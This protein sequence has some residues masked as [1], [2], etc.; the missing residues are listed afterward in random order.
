MANALHP[1]FESFQRKYFIYICIQWGNLNEET[2]T[3]RSNQRR[4]SSPLETKIRD[5]FVFVSLRA[6]TEYK[7]P[8][9]VCRRKIVVTELYSCF[10]TTLRK[11]YLLF[12]EPTASVV[13]KFPPLPPLFSLSTRRISFRWNYFLGNFDTR[14]EY[15]KNDAT[16]SLVRR[17]SAFL[18]KN[19]GAS[20]R[21]SCVARHRYYISWQATFT[22]LCF[23][24]KKLT[25]FQ[26]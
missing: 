12:N 15:G 6:Y 17:T 13:S 4:I 26:I 20:S 23:S 22:C 7:S 14:R 11:Q 16:G 24:W 21:S 8:S 2:Q 3:K 1:F 9:L 10:E 19:G 25:L 18:R 5:L